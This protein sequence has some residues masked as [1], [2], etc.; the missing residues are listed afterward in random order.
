MKK[1]WG[2]NWH[3]YFLSNAME[4]LLEND[5]KALAALTFRSC[6]RHLFTSFRYM[7]IYTFNANREGDMQRQAYIVH[8]VCAKSH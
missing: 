4:R 3:R 8:H 5:G 6:S 2:I 7:I 1:E